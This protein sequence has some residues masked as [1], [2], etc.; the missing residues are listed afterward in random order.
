MGAAVGLLLYLSVLE[1]VGLGCRVA[2]RSVCAGG[3][4]G[5]RWCETLGWARGGCG[6]GFES[7]GERGF[8][9][10]VRVLKREVTAVA[11]RGS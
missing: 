8:A 2:G 1:G 3:T 9:R 4:A 11:K 7:G 5:V 10:H 6:R